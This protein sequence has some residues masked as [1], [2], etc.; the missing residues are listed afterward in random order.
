[1]PQVSLSASVN[2]Q[3]PGGDTVNQAVVAVGSYAASSLGTV[4]VP[5]GA[6]SGATFS[7]PLGAVGAPVFG[8]L[9]NSVGTTIVVRTQG[10]PTGLPLDN[11]GVWIF[12]NNRTPPAAAGP[13]SALVIQLTAAQTA[14]G[15]VD[16]LIF[17]D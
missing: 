16:Y 9:K 14:P 5:S 8:Y 2:Y 12:G 1:M 3:V 10:N 6:A 11:G 15:S 17:G 13:L 4:D 7:P